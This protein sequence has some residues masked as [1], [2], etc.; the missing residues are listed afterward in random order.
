MPIANAIRFNSL[1]EILAYAEQC[2]GS[3]VEALKDW[4]LAQNIKH[5]AITIRMSAKGPALKAPFL[6]RKLAKLRKNK[7]FKDGI[8]SGFTIPGKFTDFIPD[9]NISTEQA[10]DDLRNAIDTF[11]RA[12]TYFPH[13]I[14]EKFTRQEWI[15]FHCRHGELHL[16]NVQIVE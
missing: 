16:G 7:M 14:F 11:N 6:I 1:D 2:A 12:N 10:L 15:T 3:R 5:L 4:S 13:P 9:P 8:P